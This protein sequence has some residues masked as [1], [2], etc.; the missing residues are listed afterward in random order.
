KHGCTPNDVPP[1]VS[2]A[3]AS[4]ERL[5]RGQNS[6]GE[7]DARD[8]EP[9]RQLDARGRNRV[10]AVRETCGARGPGSDRR[11]TRGR[12]VGAGDVPGRDL[13]LQAMVDISRRDT[14][15]LDG[16]TGDAPA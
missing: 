14:I 2:H 13:D 12:G 11:P 7:F 16:R 1:G 6:R 15:G 3:E 8:D 10:T 4:S 9:L 5:P